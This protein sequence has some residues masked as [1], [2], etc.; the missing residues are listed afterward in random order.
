MV[1][2]VISVWPCCGISGAVL[3]S[4]GKHFVYCTDL[5]R[6]W[7]CPIL[8]VDTSKE[9]H[10]WLLDNALPTLNTKPSSWATFIRLWR[11]LSCSSSSLP[12]MTASSAIPIMPI[13]EVKCLVHHALGD[14]L[15]TGHALGKQTKFYHPHHVL[16]VVSQFMCDFLHQKSSTMVPFDG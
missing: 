5:N 1:Q 7:V 3:L 9:G 11:C 8:V 12:W 15:C 14:V 13:T 10:R 6:V 16:K 4:L 2:M